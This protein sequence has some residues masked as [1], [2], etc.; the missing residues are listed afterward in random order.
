MKRSFLSNLAFLLLLNLIV[1]PFWILGID[2][3]VQ[4]VTGP[5]T[6][7]VYFS[8]FNF[9][10]LFQ[11]LLDFGFNNFNNRYIARH[12]EQL[13]RYFSTMIV[14]KLLF[15][16]AYA[17]VAW[18]VAI[19][20]GFNNEHIQLLGLILI[21]QILLSFFTYLRSNIAALHLFRSD[22]WLSISD[23]IFSSILCAIL[24]WTNIFP[25]EISIRNFIL[26]QIAGYSLSCLLG[27][28]ILYWRKQRLVW[29]PD[30]ALIREVIR[31]SMPYALLTFL[32]A[33]YYRIDGVMLER[34]LGPEGPEQAGIYASAFRLLDALTIIG[35]MF[36]A[37]L[38]PTFSRMFEK[39]EA[40]QNL[41][42]LGLRAI[43][44]V[45][46]PMAAGFFFFRQEL[47]H[48]L[49]VKSD[50]HYGNIFG[51]LMIGFLLIS[52]V[53]IFGTL[54]TARGNLRTL[55]LIAVVGL[56]LNILLNVWLIP[57]YQAE[58]AAIATLCTQFIVTLLHIMATY[59]LPGLSCNK[60]VWWRIGLLLVLT[61][62][63]ALV[64]SQFSPVHW[65]LSMALAIA[66]GGMMALTLRLLTRSD[67][68]PALSMRE[69]PIA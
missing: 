35:Y 46:I 30:P 48:L 26:A 63:F 17:L 20:I 53:Y 14:A 22:A 23:K 39:G 2:R 42:D 61:S 44:S 1:K 38:L 69:D 59:Q 58:G 8:L 60:S 4:N 21:S 47:M 24:L 25:W 6:Y 66:V 10:L 12:P 65:A 64:M 56:G 11:V 51:L 33:A 41:M 34:M 54:L 7:G 19:G 29:Q 62:G 55:N 49:Y 68:Q 45:T 57:K 28:T 16:F 43:A 52:M 9:S 37:I 3:T 18:A 40:V 15:A 31:K 50:Q 13:G 32:M 27:V 67:L 36:A 5:E